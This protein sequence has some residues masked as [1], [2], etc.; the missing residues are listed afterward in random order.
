MKLPSWNKHSNGL[1]TL[2]IEKHDSPIIRLSII[3]PFGSYE[4]PAGKDGLTNFVG[5]MLLR[6]TKSKKRKEI[7]LALDQLGASLNIYTG[8]HSITVESRVLSR[9]FPQLLSLIKELISSPLFD[10][11]EVKKLKNEIKADLALRLEDDQDLAKINFFREIYNNHPYSRDVLGKHSTI[12]SFEIED[13]E[14]QFK[15][16]FHRNGLLIGAAGNIE[17][18]K[19]EKAAS[20]IYEVLPQSNLERS[21]KQFDHQVSGKNI[22]LVDKPGLTQTQFFIGR[23]G[24]SA[25]D[26]TFIPLSVF[27][28][29]FAGG[30]FQAKYMQEIRVKRG[31][32]YGA[33]G[34]IDARRDG[35]SVYLYTF[36]KNDDTIDAIDV[37]LKL[38]DEALSGS[39][40]GEDAI[41]FAKNYMT[42]SFPFKVDTPEKILAQK[43]YGKLVGR[44]EDATEHFQE[45]VQSVTYEQAI[46]TA[47]KYLSSEHVN[48]VVVCT[49][50]N[51]EKPY[52]KEFNQIN[53][54]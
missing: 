8:F 39:L 21:I 42:R 2:L 33:Y 48:I 31:W 37:S 26:D 1:E 32:S 44:P 14:S 13:L 22:T 29:A 4:D 43:V 54:L 18:E 50:S 23:S 30:M 38:V 17:P 27:M 36:P 41:T 35:G 51:F 20:E 19:F 28:T 6:G 9:N 49:A 3:F 25:N 34:S 40:V 10:P 53:F 16:T 46:E 7:E 5:D 24:I 15:K 12:E 47:R 45:K 52:K 11:S